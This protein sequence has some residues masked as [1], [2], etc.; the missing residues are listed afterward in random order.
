MSSKKT[1]KLK[2]GAT[3]WRALANKAN[4]AFTLIELLVVIAIIAILAALLLPALARAK[5]KAQQIQCLSN[6]KQIGLG[7]SMYVP[8]WSDSFPRHPDWA[9]VGGGDGGFEMFTAA[10]NRP[11]NP[12]VPNL[13][14][15][16]CPADK[17]DS[18]NPGV[19]NCFKVYGNSYLVQWADRLVQDPVDPE[20]HSK[21]F[22]FRTRSVTAPSPRE[23]PGITP[24]KPT[25]LA[26][27]VAT[28]IVQGDWVW[29]PNRA[30]TDAKS[31]WH[32]FRGKSLSVMLFAD[33]HG[34]AYKFPPE[35]SRWERSP[36]PDPNYP[37]W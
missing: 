2:P 21:R 15:F 24:M 23:D 22:A 4:H 27:N 31:V 3:G 34:A 28:K 5:A 12:Y 19:S 8:D 26:G 1:T 6:Q 36:P 30:N 35:M 29:H 37:W 13:Q 33:G 16:R 7:F 18:V 11:L 32:N 17:G 25:A 9:S 10:T 14:A 20:D